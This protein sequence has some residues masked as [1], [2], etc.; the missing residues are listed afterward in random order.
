[1]YCTSCGYLIVENLN[2]CSNCGEIQK[3]IIA[4]K[5]NKLKNFIKSDIDDVPEETDC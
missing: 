5:E 1:M 3:E 2:I 4:E